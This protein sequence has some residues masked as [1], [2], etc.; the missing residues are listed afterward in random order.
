MAP[1]DNQQERLA[2]VAGLMAGEGWFGIT[3]QRRTKTLQL[4][5]RFSMQMDDT[6]TIHVASET[7]T[8][9]G[10]PHYVTSD[11]RRID[12]S[13]HKRMSRLL[14]VMVPLLTGHKQR[15]ARTVLEWIKY[16][17]DQTD[18]CNYTEKD[19][20]FVNAVRALNAG[21]GKDKLIHASILRDYTLGTRKKRVKI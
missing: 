16:R 11:G 10:L 2:Y 7:L 18:F 14:P 4:R 1:M 8:A 3:V 19:L 9:A 6:E 12:V 5:A 20:E 15:V 17:E 13:G 21:N